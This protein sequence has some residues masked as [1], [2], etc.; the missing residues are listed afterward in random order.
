MLYKEYLNIYADCSNAFKHFLYWCISDDEKAKF[1]RVRRDVPYLEILSELNEDELRIAKSCVIKK[2]EHSNEI[3]LV[4]L[5]QQLG[6]E[7][8]VPLVVEKMNFFQEKCNKNN[9]N[10]DSCIK[11]CNE[12]LN[13]LKKVK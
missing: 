4:L 1:A 2:M 12:A 5:I 8:V 3:F 7:N 6:D 13:S 9:G 11:I 10:F